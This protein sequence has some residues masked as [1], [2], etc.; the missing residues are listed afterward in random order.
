[1][2][3]FTR[4]G[5]VVTIA[6][7]LPFAVQRDGWGD[8]ALPVPA[9]TWRDVVTGDEVGPG[10]APLAGLLARFPVAILERLD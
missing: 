6:P 8:T 3:A 7:R 4:A 9:G 5:E 2:V 10:P 1:M